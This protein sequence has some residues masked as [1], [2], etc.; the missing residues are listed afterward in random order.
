MGLI[1]MLAEQLTHVTSHNIARDATATLYHT[2]MGIGN[3][4]LI[5]QNARVRARKLSNDVTTMRSQ[6]V[7]Q[8]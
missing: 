6:L 4:F 5:C 2:H 3:V 1:E 8:K 7:S